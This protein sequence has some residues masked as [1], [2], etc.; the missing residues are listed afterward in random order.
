MGKI[1]YLGVLSFFSTQNQVAQNDN[2]NGSSDISYSVEKNSFKILKFSSN[3][4]KLKRA[5]RLFIGNETLA[6]FYSKLF[7]AIFEIKTTKVQYCI[8][9]IEK[10]N[11]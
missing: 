2:R 3:S 11:F 5:S 1:W 9:K 8:K 4:E 7:S 10:K 6:S